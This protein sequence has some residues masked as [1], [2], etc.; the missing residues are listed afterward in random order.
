[1]KW[2][3]TQAK[4]RAYHNLQ[5]FQERQKYDP[6]RV[7]TS[8]HQVRKVGQGATVSGPSEGQ[9]EA[10]VCH[11]HRAGPE[12]K[13]HRPW[14][15]VRVQGPG[16]AAKGSLLLGERGA[17][18]EEQENRHARQFQGRP[19]RRSP[20]SRIIHEPPLS[21]PR[22]TGPHSR[23]STGRRRRTSHS[24]PGPIAQSR[25][26]PCITRLP[27]QVG[28]AETQSAVTSKVTRTDTWRAKSRKT[29]WPPI[30][31]DSAQCATRS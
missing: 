25:A 18:E 29:T 24:G 11:R 6:R 26:A 12:E 14:R 3:W 10:G 27:R 9:P 21:K 28:L 1:M 5:P 17:L 22:A 23:S 16:I 15:Q 20:P 31:W 8:S 19:N 7:S 2:R 4:P 30:L 13:W